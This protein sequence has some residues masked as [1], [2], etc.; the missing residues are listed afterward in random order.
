MK[1]ILTLVIYVNILSFQQYF[2]LSLRLWTECLPVLEI[3]GIGPPLQ[4]YLYSS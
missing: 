3:P 2:D 4:A 1:L